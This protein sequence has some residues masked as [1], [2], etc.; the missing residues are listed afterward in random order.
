MWGAGERVQ[1]QS[2]G[3]RGK[4]VDHSGPEGR[5]LWP[6]KPGNKRK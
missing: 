2:K 1:A 5:Q 6:P 4:E 3:A